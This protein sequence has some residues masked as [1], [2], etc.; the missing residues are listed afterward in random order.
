M[1]SLKSAER[2]A[3]M[4]NFDSAFFLSFVQVESFDGYPWLQG[5]AKGNLLIIENDE[6]ASAIGFYGGSV[7]SCQI[8]SGESR[9]DVIDK[10]IR[11]NLVGELAS[12]FNTN[13]SR[14]FF[15][16]LIVGCIDGD[17][18]DF[19]YEN[20]LSTTALGDDSEPDVDLSHYLGCRGVSVSQLNETSIF[21]ATS[22]KEL[23]FQE[24]V[25][26]KIFSI[27]EIGEALEARGETFAVLLPSSVSGSN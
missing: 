12:F 10:F 25:K 1:D 14:E 13:V 23:A 8:F 15:S 16:E 11:E 5:F 22:S 6:A 20:N 26:S 19:E 9:H 18:S 21:Y 27:E 24:G 4:L 17:L 7:D 2:K 3:S